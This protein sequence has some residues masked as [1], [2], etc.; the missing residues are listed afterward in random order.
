MKKDKFLEAVRRAGFESAGWQDAAQT[1]ISF[2]AMGINCMMFLYM[3]STDVISVQL[4][5]GFAETVRE[6]K[7]SAWNR[8]NRFLKAYNFA[9]GKL[10]VEM[11]VLIPKE[12]SDDLLVD[13]RDIWSHLLARLSD[14]FS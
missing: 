6:D 12:F 2:R 14:Y 5:A 1:R 11:D 10:S 4:F 3:A 13:S 8:D 7:I 9:P